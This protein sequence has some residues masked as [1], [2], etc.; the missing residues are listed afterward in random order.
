MDELGGWISEW[1]YELIGGAAE[2]SGAGEPEHIRLARPAHH[3]TGQ[4][5]LPGA[6]TDCT[7]L[8]SVAAAQRGPLIAAMVPSERRLCVKRSVPSRR[9]SV[10]ITSHTPSTNVNAGSALP[11]RVY[12][13]DGVDDTHVCFRQS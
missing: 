11:A 6:R 1:V 4:R 5:S 9:S 8:V 10:S 7:E 3:P 2:W 13:A 12:E